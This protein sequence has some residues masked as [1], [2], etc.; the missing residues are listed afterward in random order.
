MT[1]TS[2]YSDEDADVR[3]KT[4]DIVRTGDQSSISC[5]T[6]ILTYISHNDIPGV[7]WD[8][9]MPAMMQFQLNNSISP[10][11]E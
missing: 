2:V 5:L 8:K 10:L 7:I 4:V 9:A 3:R 11:D 1:I 6:S